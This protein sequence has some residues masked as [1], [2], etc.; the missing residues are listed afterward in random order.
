MV[1]EPEWLAPVVRV[2]R[3][4]RFLFLKYLRRREIPHTIPEKRDQV[5]HPPGLGGRP[6]ARFRP[7][8]VQTQ[9]QG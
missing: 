3:T 7:R 4:G 1:R 2:K 8:D 5:G 9:A 6:P